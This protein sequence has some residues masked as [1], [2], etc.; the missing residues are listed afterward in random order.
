[1]AL[2]FHL[3]SI[4]VTRSVLSPRS[5][6]APAAAAPA[7]DQAAGLGL[8][9]LLSV[10]ILQNRCLGAT[11]NNGEVIL[12]PSL[13]YREHDALFLLAVAALRDGKPPREPK[14]GT[15][16]V[17][18][19]NKLD[20]LEDMFEPAPLHQSWVAKPSWQVITALACIPPQP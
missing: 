17:S 15:F 7:N 8:D 14:L 11:Y 13:L 19:L 10:A 2:A 12:Q 4:L 6:A 18:G 16:R 5:A 3:A 1:M 20:L 9:T